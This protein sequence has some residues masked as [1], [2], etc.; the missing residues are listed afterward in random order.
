MKLE[1]PREELPSIYKKL[2]ER[3]NAL[4]AHLLKETEAWRLLKINDLD[5]LLKEKASLAKA[6][7]AALDALKERETSLL[8]KTFPPHL[9]KK[10]EEMDVLLSQNQTA[11]NGAGI[12]HRA[13]VDSIK[14]R[15]ETMGKTRVPSYTHYGQMASMASQKKG[16]PLNMDVFS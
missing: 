16:N 12:F 7:T 5:I 15:A 1:R 8:K 3:L 10:I 6:Y 9:I 2:E 13:F 4:K 11:I 14:E